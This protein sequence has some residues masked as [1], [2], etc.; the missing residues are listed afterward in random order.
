MILRNRNLLQRRVVQINVNFWLDSM[1][2]I[3]IWKAEV[4]FETEC[5]EIC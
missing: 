3:F 2:T 4:S 1:K 5:N